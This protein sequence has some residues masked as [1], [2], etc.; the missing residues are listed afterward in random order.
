MTDESRS[1]TLEDAY[2][3]GRADERA[4]IVEFMIRMHQTE[5]MRHNYALYYA[6]LI[7]QMDIPRN[8][9]AKP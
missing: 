9:D 8:T 1:P 6:R 4:A 3:E 7:E 2:A 5:M